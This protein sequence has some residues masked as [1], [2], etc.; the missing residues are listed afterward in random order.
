MQTWGRLPQPQRFPV[1]YVEHRS[2]N[3]L[4]DVELESKLCSLLGVDCLWRGFVAFSCFEG[5][6]M[7]G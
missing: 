2:V 7:P 4:L 5:V 1:T 6:H 3:V